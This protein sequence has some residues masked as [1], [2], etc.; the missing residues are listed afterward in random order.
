MESDWRRETWSSSPPVDTP[1]PLPGP[2]LKRTWWGTFFVS[3]WASKERGASA[4]QG[5]I[6]QVHSRS[7]LTLTNRHCPP[8]RRMQVKS[9]TRKP[10]RHVA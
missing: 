2:K 7:V 6:A 3:T 10:A 4:K 9:S 1:V 5:G 8:V